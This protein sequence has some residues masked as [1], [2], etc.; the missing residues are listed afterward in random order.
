MNQAKAVAMM[1]E[2]KRERIR[3]ERFRARGSMAMASKC[4]TTARALYMRAMIAR[5]YAPTDAER[6]A[7][8]FA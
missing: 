3:G 5:G 4:S 2:A 6:L 7:Y 1:S 8:Q